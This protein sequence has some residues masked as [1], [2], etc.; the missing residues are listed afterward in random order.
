MQ[1]G[2]LIGYSALLAAAVLVGWRWARLRPLAFAVGIVSGP[3][4]LFY[5]LF[6]WLPDVLDGRETMLF[7]LMLRYQVL[8]IA[9]LVLGLAVLRQRGRP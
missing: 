5:I 2:L 6:L 8:G 9:A 7:S 3:H 4:A 1:I